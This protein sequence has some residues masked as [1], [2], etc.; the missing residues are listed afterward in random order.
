MGP[1]IPPR[2]NA[3]MAMFLRLLE[4]CT[5]EYKDF[6]IGPVH[7]ED[8][9]LAHITLFEKPSASGR[10]LCVEPICHWSDFASKVAELYPNYKV[11][12]FPKDTQPGLVRAEG[13]PKKLMALGLQFTPLEKIIRDAVESLRS[14]GCIA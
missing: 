14:R 3:S 12:K 6:F 9:A 4:G 5:E 7:V 13:V 11:P 1:M 2:I 10:H 8:V